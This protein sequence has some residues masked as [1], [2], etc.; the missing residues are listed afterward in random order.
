MSSFIN[1]SRVFLDNPATNVEEVFAFLSDKAVELGISDDR[2]AVLKAFEAREALGSTGM[3]GGFAIPH[4]KT[5]AVKEAAL[6]AVKFENELDWA[7]QDG[8]PIKAAIA[9]FAP[10]SDPTTYLSLLS[11]VAVLLVNE[12]FCWKFLASSDVTEIAN[13]VAAGL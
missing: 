13:A 9:L 5:D 12:N 1:S 3:H 2:E 4:A 6:I 10:A 7:S 11:K 8:Q